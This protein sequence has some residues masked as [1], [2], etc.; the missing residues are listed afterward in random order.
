MSYFCL[1]LCIIGLFIAYGSWSEAKT[2]YK[3]DLETFGD[4]KQYDRVEEYIKLQKTE[5]RIAKNLIIA[6]LIF[7]SLGLVE[8][9]YTSSE[10]CDEAFDRSGILYRHN[11]DLRDKYGSYGNCMTSWPIIY[12]GPSPDENY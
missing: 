2:R 12:D 7:I 3:S 5:K 6:L 11:E 8:R 4:N 1:W 9:Y 10:A